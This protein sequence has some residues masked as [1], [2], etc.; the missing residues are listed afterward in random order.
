[1]LVQIHNQQWGDIEN[2]DILN[3]LPP[4]LVKKLQWEK[5]YVED[6]QLNAREIST[7]SGDI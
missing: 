4:N 2:A 3:T 1:M 7:S 6:I 5:E